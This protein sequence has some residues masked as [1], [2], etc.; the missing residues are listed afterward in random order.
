MRVKGTTIGWQVGQR[1]V[2]NRSEQLLTGCFIVATDKDSVTVSCPAIGLVVSGQ[3]HALEEMGWS[4]EQQVKLQFARS[5][6]PN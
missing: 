4:P 2:C 3:Q 6:E 1:M 5:G